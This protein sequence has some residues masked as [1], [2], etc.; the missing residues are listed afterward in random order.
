M[1]PAGSMQWERVVRPCEAASD[2]NWALSVGVTV[3]NLVG[4]GYCLTLLSG[5]EGECFN[6]WHMDRTPCS[7]CTD[8]NTTAWEAEHGF[9]PFGSCRAAFV[10]RAT[11]NGTDVSVPSECYQMP[12]L[13]A[14]RNS[15]AGAF[16]SVEPLLL[17]CVSHWL[18]ACF[19]AFHAA[20][21]LLAEPR[22][23]HWAVGSLALA[24]LIVFP[25]A[26]PGDA[27][28]APSLVVSISLCVASTV[29]IFLATSDHGNMHPE[30]T[31][32]IL[33]VLDSGLAISLC[34][35]SLLALSGVQLELVYNLVFV[36]SMASQFVIAAA[37]AY[38]EITCEGGDAET[39]KKPFLSLAAD[40]VVPAAPAARLAVDVP[41]LACMVMPDDVPA[42]RC[43][44]AW[45]SGASAGRGRSSA[46]PGGSSTCST[47]SVSTLAVA[48]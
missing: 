28:C 34:S 21:A 17:L 19:A 11:W 30:R 48:R 42:R 43:T 1:T 39:D 14:K 8:L 32:L 46:S 27:I 22:I 16:S 41:C 13:F 3:A 37:I 2:S 7:Q 12:P 31:L 4:F 10:G 26:L 29:I 6:T 47:A 36:C 40:E 9:E 45:S 44:S 20:T 25:L 18:G 24:P 15:I 33:R 23:L 38:P 5:G 35:T